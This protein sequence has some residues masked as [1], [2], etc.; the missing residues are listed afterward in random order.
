M[1]ENLD[2]Q[3]VSQNISGPALK[4]I[5]VGD[6]TKLE[7]L[8]A[9]TVNVGCVYPLKSILRDGQTTGSSTYVNNSL[10]D[11]KVVGARAGKYYRLGWYGNGTTAYG[12][13]NYEMLFT[14]YDASLFST[15]SASG[16]VVAVA[17]NDI[18]ASSIES[19]DI[20]T[21]AF[22][23]SRI[24]GLT[25]IVTYRPSAM[26]GTSTS[27]DM[28][29]TI[30]GY[31]W[32]W[33][34]DPSN[35]IYAVEK[36]ILPG[37]LPTIPVTL[38]PSSLEVNRGKSYPLK[39]AMRNG[40]TSAAPQKFLDA[41]LDIK[42]VGVPKGYYLRL[43]WYGNGT[44]A[45]GAPNYGMIFELAVDST[46]SSSA[47]AEIVV[48]HTDATFD[49]QIVSGTILTR[50]YRTTLKSGLA[51]SI[52][53]DKAVFDTTAGTYVAANYN[54]NSGYS[55]IVDPDCYIPTVSFISRCALVY[56]HTDTETL[57]A[58]RYSETQD[59]RIAI[60]RYG[61]NELND[62]GT[63]SLKTHGGAELSLGGT[64]VTMTARATDWIGP[65]VVNAD[66][67]G[68]GSITQF[69][70]GNHGYTGAG[71]A[72]TAHQVYRRVFADGRPLISGETG[73]ASLISFQW[74]NLVQGSN[75]RD[76]PRDI[77]R[78]QHS[79]T[80]RPG[81]I[82]TSARITAL[83]ALTVSTYH[84]LQAYL[85]G[86]NST[87]HFLNGQ[88]SARVAWA[89][90]LSSG[91]ISGYPNVLAT[92]VRGANG[93]DL[94]MWVDR[95]Y[96]VANLAN[97]PSTT[98]LFFTS[99]TKA[100]TRLVESTL[101]LSLAA[102]ESFVWRGGYAMAPNLGVGID[103]GA[104]YYDA[105]KETFVAALTG[106]GSGRINLPTP[107]ASGRALTVQSGSVVF[108]DR[109]EPDGMAVSASGYAVGFAS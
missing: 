84:G 63:I 69:T 80:I 65:F 68:S 23:S 8:T 87:V 105:G 71:G 74:E 75:T 49:E 16:S 66:A 61:V 97:L 22:A 83:E 40:A 93:F 34:I 53:Y 54:Y 73:S 21:R 24:E 106:A 56:S 108:S 2:I 45:F 103:L 7:A 92:N 99:S 101:P 76:V 35:Y 62:I 30:G 86:F 102:G 77:L 51:I 38:L 85:A 36:D 107:D 11:I 90:G 26:P 15:N 50:N 18:P 10:L 104:R 47:A 17:L 43:A 1:A 70:G 98:N 20:I 6:A 89:D 5:L 41:V 3:T 44:T 58:W 64:W 59:L 95:S 4:T 29:S 109:V 55:W 32:S 57:I 100:Y 31:C 33:I 91:A 94:L 67:G 19:G 48:A 42:A 13:P 72:A 12:A 78:E 81:S 39:S 79:F 46:Y 88:Q 9:Q 96:G 52:T 14:E 25:F 27:I 37:N 28:Q 60:S 82:E